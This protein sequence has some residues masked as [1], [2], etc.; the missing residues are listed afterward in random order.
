MKEE[1]F[2]TAS[3]LAKILKYYPKE[4][5]LESRLMFGNRH[6]IPKKTFETILLNYLSLAD[7]FKEIKPWHI[8][9]DTYYGVERLRDE[10]G[11]IT[12]QL[13]DLIQ[14][15]DYE[16]K[17]KD[18]NIRLSLKIDKTIESLTQQKQTHQQLKRVASFCDELFVINFIQ[19]WSNNETKPWYNIEVEVDGSSELLKEISS[20]DL[21]KNL[22]IR[23]LELQGGGL[24][25][26]QQLH[27]KTYSS[28]A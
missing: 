14:N 28:N 24:N 21:I 4:Y 27:H 8:V 9:K 7:Q 20:E 6:S 25:Q 23:T 13:K 17:D 2:K 3:H 26:V 15:L 19:T 12:T 16:V 1:I 10:N 11:V 22:I 5:E 18:L